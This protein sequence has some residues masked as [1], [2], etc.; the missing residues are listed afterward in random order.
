MTGFLNTALSTTPWAVLFFDTFFI[1]DVCFFFLKIADWGDA[2][3][4]YIVVSVEITVDAMENGE[5]LES[6]DV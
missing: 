2:M 1:L 4:E 5:G 3:S 6:A